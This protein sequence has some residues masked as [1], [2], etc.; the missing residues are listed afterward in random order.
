ML[1]I[2]FSDLSQSAQSAI[3]GH[4][5]ICS[6]ADLNLNIVPLVILPFDRNQIIEADADEVDEVN[7]NYESK[8]EIREAEFAYEFS[9]VSE[10]D[11]MPF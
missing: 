8:R 2:Y 9:G 10:A 6:P 3:L 5:Q 7:S 4:Y 11:D 1:E